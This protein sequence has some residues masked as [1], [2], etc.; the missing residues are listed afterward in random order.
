MPLSLV[1]RNSLLALLLG[2]PAAVLASCPAPT[3]DQ[4]SI[5]TLRVEVGSVQSVS[6]KKLATM[7]GRVQNNHTRFGLVQAKIQ[8]Q[9]N[10]SAIIKKDG[11]GGTCLYPKLELTIGFAPM[12]ISI[13]SELPYQGCAY[14]A[15]L[16]HELTHV[17]IYQKHLPKLIHQIEEGLRPVF[18]QGFATG[19]PKGLHKQIGADTHKY[20]KGLVEYEMAIAKQAQ[21]AFDDQDSEAT[22]RGPCAHEFK[23]AYKNRQ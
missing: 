10:V 4:L 1:A 17:K 16:N 6:L 9:A 18:S 13:A 5:N 22:V 15:V 23:A 21:E 19:D 8:H 12:D 14:N 20:L 7:S 3:T 2:S 11:S